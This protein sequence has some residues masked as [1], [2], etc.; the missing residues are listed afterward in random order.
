MPNIEDKLKL[1]ARIV[2]LRSE[3]A[4][5]EAKFA[6]SEAP[7]RVKPVRGVVRSGPSVA[8]RT[9]SLITDSGDSGIERAVI[10][11]VIGHDAAVDSALKQHAARGNIRNQDGR[12]FRVQQKEGPQ[13]SG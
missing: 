13:P 6:A 10:K 3:L 12:W 1:A 11:T 9:L 7:R 8:Q 4:E 5:L 2:A